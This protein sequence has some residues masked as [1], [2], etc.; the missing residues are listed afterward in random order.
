MTLRELISVIREDYRTN[1]GDWT[2]PGF[3]ALAV[4]RFGVWRVTQPKL[5]RF[6]AFFVYRMLYRLVRN[7]YGIELA[8]STKIGRRFLIGHQSGIVIH[9]FAHIGDDCVIRQNV[10]IGATRSDRFGEAPKLGCGVEVGAGAVIAGGV[11]IGDH[12][13]I[14]PNVV[15]MRD[16]PA[17]A[18]VMVRPPQLISVPGEMPPPAATSGPLPDPPAG[19]GRTKE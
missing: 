7:L 9:P 11:E 1:G 8:Y 4:Y 14:G 12:A 16:V 6:P 2:R 10:T 19:A 17:G 13:R 15:I 5:I 3:R 18:I